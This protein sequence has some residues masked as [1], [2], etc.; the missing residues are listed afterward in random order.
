MKR[1]ALAECDFHRDRMARCCAQLDDAATIDA[2]TY[3]NARR[4]TR[5]A[6]RLAH[7]SA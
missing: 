3:D 5:R 4:I 6:R 7:R 1:S 2:D